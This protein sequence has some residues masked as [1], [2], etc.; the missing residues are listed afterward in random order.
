ME[1]IL[2]ELP[3]HFDDF[4]WWGRHQGSRLATQFLVLKSNVP[5]VF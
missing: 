3:N 5:V 4:R 1:D 2:D